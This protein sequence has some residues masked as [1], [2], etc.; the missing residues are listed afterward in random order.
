MPLD[1]IEV[2]EKDF[3]LMVQ[4]EESNVDITNWKLP[5]YKS[6]VVLEEND[7]LN[8]VIGNPIF[9]EYVEENKCKSFKYYK[10]VRRHDHDFQVL[11]ARVGTFDKKTEMW[12]RSIKE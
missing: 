3:L 7:S 4:A 5:Y 11:Y 1:L 9:M 6:L 12:L 2:I 10:I 8:Q